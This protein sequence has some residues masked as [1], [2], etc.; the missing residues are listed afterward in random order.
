M[1]KV[2]PVE[3]LYSSIVYK[4][5]FLLIPTESAV[6]ICRNILVFN[7]AGS[8]TEYITHEGQGDIILD[9]NLK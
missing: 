5:D 4:H 1:M 9:V 8:S 3:Y 6:C 2:A 7:F